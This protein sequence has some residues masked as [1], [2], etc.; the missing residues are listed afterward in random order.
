MLDVCGLCLDS[1]RKQYGDD[2]IDGICASCT[3]N[4]NENEIRNNSNVK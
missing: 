1:T 3:D 4:Q 2:L